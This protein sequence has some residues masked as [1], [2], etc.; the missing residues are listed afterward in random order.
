MRQAEAFSHI[1][2]KDEDKRSF[3]YRATI[4]RDIDLNGDRAAAHKKFDGR[5]ITSN[6]TEVV[7]KW[8]TVYWLQRIAGAWKITGFLGYLPNPMP[9]EIRGPVTSGIRLPSGAVQHRTAGPYSPVLEVTSQTWIAVSGQ[10]PIDSE[11]AIVGKTLE[12]QAVVALEGCKRQLM[13]AG[14]SMADVF[15]VTVYLADIGEWN[16]FNDVYRR[17][18]EPPYP[19]RTAIQASLWGGVRVEVELMAVSPNERTQCFLKG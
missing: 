16:S 18:F 11:G 12:E 6:G 2:L 9:E 10:G 17:Y 4:L 7:L 14:A 3:L 13:A 5:A 15:K 19:T 1:Q 8:Q